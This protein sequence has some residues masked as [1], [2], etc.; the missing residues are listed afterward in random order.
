I[1]PRLAKLSELFDSKS[2]DDDNK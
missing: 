2:K 1:D